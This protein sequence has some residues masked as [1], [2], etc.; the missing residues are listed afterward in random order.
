VKRVQAVVVRQ[1]V[2]DDRLPGR[3]HPPGEALPPLEPGA[4]GAAVAPL[5][6][7]HQLVTI[8]QPKASGLEAE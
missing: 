5:G 1:I 7:D 8:D 3:G 2:D 6:R 4:E